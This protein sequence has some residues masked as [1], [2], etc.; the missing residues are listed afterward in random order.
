MKQIHFD[1]A[2][3]EAMNKLMD[4]HGDMPQ[5]V[6]SFHHYMG[7]LLNSFTGFAQRRL[8][9]SCHMSCARAIL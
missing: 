7:K 3:Q 1:L 6:T 2:D 5:V 8:I 9:H 4:E